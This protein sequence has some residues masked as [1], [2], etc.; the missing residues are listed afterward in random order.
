MPD[1][2]GFAAVAPYLTNPLSL[3]GYVLFLFFGIHR[4][5]IKAGILPPV[6]QR[7]GGKIVQLL[8]KCGFIL[9]LVVIV[10]GFGLAA[11]QGDG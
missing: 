8:L 1:A 7:T 5:L 9:A 6:T 3:V 2:P 10:V 4:G 11:L